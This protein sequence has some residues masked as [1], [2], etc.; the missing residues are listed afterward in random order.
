MTFHCAHNYGAVLQAYAL[1]NVLIQKG[2][3]CE[4]IDY[5]PEG[6][7]NYTALYTK[8]NGLKS[9]IKNLML[10]KYD[11]PRRNRA[12]KFNDFI[13]NNLVLSKE[14]NHNSELMSDLTTKY[15]LFIVGSDQVWNTKKT[16]EVNSTYFL[17]FVY[18]GNKKVAYAASVGNAQRVDLIGY[19]DLLRQFKAISCREYRGSEVIKSLLGKDIPVVLDPTL[20]CDIQIWDTLQSKSN[21]PE[22]KNY[23]LYYSLDGYDKRKDNIEELKILSKR[24]NKKIL[25]I[26]PEW[27]R[28]ISDFI[29]LLDVGP[30]DFLKLIKS[31]DLVCTN[32]FHGTALSIAFNKDFY[33]LEEYNGTDDRKIGLLKS[34]GLEDRMV[35]GYK[36]VNELKIAEINYFDVCNNLNKLKKQSFSFLDNVFNTKKLE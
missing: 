20:L 15:D 18:D 19:I 9:Y 7:E 25:L 29:D 31:A 24:L 28:C 33:V 6:L 36:Y 14:C 26:T 34:L 27:P 3:D 17:D 23:I 12:N 35:K 1:Q 16:L 13:A 10:L 11:A 4:I 8:R 21:Y 5:R 32:S 30:I 22:Y 2:H